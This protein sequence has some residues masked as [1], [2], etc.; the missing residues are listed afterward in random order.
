MPE[1][2]AALRR[3]RRDELARLADEHMQ[4]DLQPADRDALKAAASKV[5]TW[6]TIGSAVGIGLGLYVAFRL[7]TTRKV[8]FEAFKAREKPTSVVFANGRTGTLTPVLQPI[9][10]VAY[11]TLN[12]ADP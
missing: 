4:H 11:H 1:S 9:S 5:S 6:T 12:R 10:I 2:F 3:R 7:R 8:I